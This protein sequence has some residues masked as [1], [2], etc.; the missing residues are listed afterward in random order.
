MPTVRMRLTCRRFSVF[1]HMFGQLFYIFPSYFL[2]SAFFSLFSFPPRV[3]F[4]FKLPFPVLRSLVS[5]SCSCFFS[6]SFMVD[7]SSIRLDCPSISFLFSRLGCLLKSVEEGCLDW[8]SLFVREDYPY[9]PVL[10]SLLPLVSHSA[11]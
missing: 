7:Y 9:K 5:S 8:V 6:C 2:S 1:P 10:S 4:S 11:M 3:C